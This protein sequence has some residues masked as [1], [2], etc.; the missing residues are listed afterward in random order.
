MWNSL[1]PDIKLSRNVNVFKKMLKSSLLENDSQFES[2]SHFKY[3]NL[4]NLF[5]I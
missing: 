1:S 5:F 2:Q 3:C 4:L